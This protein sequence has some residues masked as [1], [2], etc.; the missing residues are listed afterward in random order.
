MPVLT[1]EFYA[2]PF[3]ILLLLIA[4]MPLRFSSFW[5]KNLNKAIVC[6]IIGLPMFFFLLVNFPIELRRALFDYVSFILLLAALFVIAGGILVTGD[7]RATPRINTAFLLFGAVIANLIGTTG[8]S[9]L[10]IRPLLR[11]ISE[12]KF[13]RHIPIFFIFVVSNIGGSLTPLGDPPLFLGFLRGVPFNW[14]LN[15]FPI[16]IVTLA[17]VLSAFYFLDVRNYRKETPQDIQR[18]ERAVVPLRVSGKINLILLLVV[19]LAIFFQTP[20]PFREIILLAML[21]LSLRVTRKETRAQNKF[22]FAPIVEVAILFAA[23]FV[24]MVPV[25]L[26][27]EERGAQLGLTHAWQFFW[28]TGGLSSVLDNAPTYLTLVSLA[29]GVTRN[30]G[31]GN[32][33]IVAGVRADLLRAISC[34][35]V[36]MGANTYIGNGPNFM[37]KAIA[38]EQKINMP[39]FFEY[40]FYSGAVL[41]PI[42][43]II[44]ILF[45]L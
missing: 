12:R 42:F 19:I 6:A 45:F 29:E 17:I 31:A 8:A 4:V 3:I 24:T 2:L 5:E 40:L 34:G 20:A 33:E 18:D 13:T 21:L 36:F 39:H 7:L 15:L 43:F 11:T 26:L 23:I 38:E 9:M 44:T 25:L 30:L 32:F 28:I 14:T 27:L 35:A 1:S 16:W 22:S 37:V 41:L 10:L